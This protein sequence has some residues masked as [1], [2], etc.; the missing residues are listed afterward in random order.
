MTTIFLL[1]IVCATLC[2]LGLA[3]YRE[4]MLTEIEGRIDEADR[5]RYPHLSW[6]FSKIRKLHRQ[7]YPQSRLWATTQF[8][9]YVFVACMFSAGLVGLFAVLTNPVR[10]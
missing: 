3:W 2:G 5:M 7:L 4:V 6:N 1:P 8:L 9:I 10:H